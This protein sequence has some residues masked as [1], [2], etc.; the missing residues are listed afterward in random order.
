MCTPAE[1][2]ND[3]LDV[4]RVAPVELVALPVPVLGKAVEEVTEEGT[5]GAT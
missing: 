2:D 3:D 4:P 5:R 1:V